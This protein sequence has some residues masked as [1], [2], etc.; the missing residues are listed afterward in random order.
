[1][2]GVNGTVP[3]LGGDRVGLVWDNDDLDRFI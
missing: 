3:G 2:D 1:M